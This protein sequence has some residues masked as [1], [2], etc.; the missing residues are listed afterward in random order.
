M[1]RLRT[2]DVS[3][4]RGLLLAVVA[5]AVKDLGHPSYRQSAR[6]YFDGQTYRNH[7]EMLELSADL[8]PTALAAIRD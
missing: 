2:N 5:Q 4:S 1:H 6:R 3:G 8:M 7:L